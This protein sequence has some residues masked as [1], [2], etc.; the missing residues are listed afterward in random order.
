MRLP[1]TL[2]LA[3]FAVGCG[4]QAANPA[5]IGPPPPSVIV[6]TVPPPPPVAVAPPPPPLAPPRPTASPDTTPVPDDPLVR[7]PDG[8]RPDG[9]EVTVLIAGSGRQ[10]QDGD[11][12]R[13]HYVGTLLDGKPFDSSRN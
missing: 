13:V 6:V 9:L 1:T 11:H 4:A 5:P 7:R 10:A 3:A 8:L 2:L 12:L